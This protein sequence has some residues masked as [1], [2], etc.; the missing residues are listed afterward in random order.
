MFREYANKIFYKN[1]KDDEEVVHIYHCHPI[2]H[3]IQG[4]VI[5]MLIIVPFFS[6]I[7]L[8]RWGFPGVAIFFFSILLAFLLLLREWYI[9]SLHAFIITNRRV[10]DIDQKGLLSRTV[11]ECRFDKIQDVSYTKKGLIQT[12]FNIGNIVIQTAGEVSNIEFDNVHA[13]EDVHK[14]I[15]ENQSS[16][17]PLRDTPQ[18]NTKSGGDDASLSQY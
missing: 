3:F 10:L 11:S 4:C 5:A 13:P 9:W 14:V 6:I 2:K 1:I 8:F 15:V 7:P 16:S 12:F 17:S 18:N